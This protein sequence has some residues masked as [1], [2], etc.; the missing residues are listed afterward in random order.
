MAFCAFIAVGTLQSC[1]DELDDLE[2][3]RTYDMYKLS[4]VIKTLKDQISAAETNCD[5]KIA[6]L[7]AQI[8]S[9]DG[10]ISDLQAQLTTLTGEIKNRVTLAELNNHLNA[11]ETNCKDYTDG[12]ISVLDG[13]IDDLNEKVD[14]NYNEFVQQIGAINTTIEQLKDTLKAECKIGIERFQLIQDSLT[15][16]D[17]K[18]NQNTAA[19]NRLNIDIAAANA[20]IDLNKKSIDSISSVLY[21]VQERLNNIEGTVDGIQE[22]VSN[23]QAQIT[24]L[25]NQYIALDQK[26]DSVKEEIMNEVNELWKQVSSNSA[27]ISLVYNELTEKIAAAEEKISDIQSE[28][29]ALTNRVNDMLTG[30]LVQGV[31]NPIFGNF[32]LPL[33]VH[34]NLAFDWYGQFDN[35]V[36]FPSALTENTYDAEPCALTPADLTF[37]TNSLSLATENFGA[38]YQVNRSLGTIYMTLNPFGHNLTAGKKFTLET[39]AGRA[40]PFEL[41]PVESDTEISF[42]YTRS[43]N[44]FYEAEV[45]MPA[46]QEAVSSCGVVIEQDLKDAAKDILNDVSKRN[47][48]NLLK[49]VYSQISGMLPAYAVRA[50]WTVGENNY[51]VVSGYDLAVTTAKPLSYKFLYGKGIDRNLPTIGHMDNILSKLIDK[52]DFK[53]ELTSSIKL[54]KFTINYTDIKIEF[55]DPSVNI[56][57]PAITVTIPAIEVKD[58]TTGI[59]VGETKETVVEVDELSGLNEAIEEGFKSAIESLGD[60]LNDQ[61]NDQIKEN[62]IKGI[63]KD[64]NEMLE[65][66]EKQIDDMLKSLEDEINGQIGDMI[67]NIVDKAEPYFEKLNKVIDVYNKVAGKISKYLKNPNNYLQVAA[68]YKANGGVGMLSNVKSDPTVFTGS[69]SAFTLFLSSYTAETVC[70]AYKKFAAIVNVYDKDGNSVRE[71]EAQNLARINAGSSRLNKVLDGRSFRISVPV[72]NMKKGY[73][74]ELVYQGLDYSGVTSTQKFYIKVK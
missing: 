42:G 57:L 39:S 13:K 37:L 33:G 28:L 73:T 43:N 60:D 46:T 2:H 7:Q 35:P 74:Y 48:L 38:G 56:K 23:Q 12:K 6:N 19:I 71:A 26:I 49:A 62:L 53:F 34:S 66:I 15:I 5:A 27:L 9:N 70:P 18:V 64:V 59:T 20:R 24:S 45:L 16:I 8:T 41:N 25:L 30:I 55:N 67:D 3:Q 32:S 52:D 69:G 22:T 68:F 31:D 54:D 4:E 17:N 50:D 47:A 21:N 1:K 29:D 14:S 36:V 63:E 44:G 40:L 11:L 51:A 61:I 10:D 65:D 72:A 58:E